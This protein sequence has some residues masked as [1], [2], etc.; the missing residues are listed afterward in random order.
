MKI[1]QT[2]HKLKITLVL[3]MAFFMHHRNRVFLINVRGH[4]KHFV[5][6]MVWKKYESHF[7]QDLYSNEA[8]KGMHVKNKNIFLA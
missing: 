6:D 7:Y 2:L 3:K 8:G 5:A 1:I 4:R